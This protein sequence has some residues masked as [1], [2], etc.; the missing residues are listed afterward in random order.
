[1]DSE[2]KSINERVQEEVVDPSSSFNVFSAGFSDE[3]LNIPSQT[4]GGSSGGGSGFFSTGGYSN[5]GGGTITVTGCPFTPSRVSVHGSFSDS[6]GASVSYGSA[7]NS[8]D[9]KYTSASGN[10]NSEYG[11]G[12]YLLTLRN[13]SGTAIKRFSFSSFTSD[14]VVITVPVS[15]GTTSYMIELFE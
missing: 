14:G 8:S 1:M 9:Q 4:R 12:T 6:S 7:T 15:A 11:S 2:I 13:S 10:G 3:K 5:T